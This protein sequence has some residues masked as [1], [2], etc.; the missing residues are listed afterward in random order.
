[1]RYDLGRKAGKKMVTIDGLLTQGKSFNEVSIPSSLE[2]IDEL[3]PITQDFVDFN[4]RESVKNEVMAALKDEE[5]YLIGV[6]GMGGV[7]KTMLMNQMRKQVQEEKLF[8]KVIL[9]TVS[10]NIDMKMIQSEIAERLILNQLKEKESISLRA[11]ILS[12]RLK[13]EKSILVILDD[14]SSANLDLLPQLGIVYGENGHKGGCKVVITSRSYDVCNSMLCQKTIQ[15]RVLSD[16]EAWNLFKKNAGDVV[17]SP[18]LETLARGI[19]KQCKGL[20]IA[21]HTLGR[22][23]RNNEDKLMWKETASQLANNCDDVILGDLDQIKRTL[24][25]VL[26]K[27]IA[28]SL[29]M[30]AIHHYRNA[31]NISFRMH[32]IVRDVAILIASEEGNGVFV[33]AGKGLSKW[34]KMGSLLSGKCLRL[35]LMRNEISV[36]PDQLP[37]LPHLLSLSFEGNKALKKFPDGFF[38]TMGSLTTLDLRQTGISSLPSSFLFLQNLRSLYLDSSDFSQ[39]KDIAEIGKLKNLEMLSLKNCKLHN[40]PEEF[41]GL[42]TLKLLD[43]GDNKLKVVPPNVISRLSRLEYLDMGGSLNYDKWEIEGDWE[44]G[45]NA[46]LAEVTSLHSLS[47]VKLKLNKKSTEKDFKHQ[48]CISFRI[49]MDMIY[50]G[51]CTLSLTPL[52]PICDSIK[53]LLRRVERLI[54]SDCTTCLNSL[55]QLVSLGVV[56]ENIA[57]ER[58]V[59]KSMDKMKQI[60]NGPIPVEYNCPELKDVFNLEEES[61]FLVIEE[62]SVDDDTFFRLREIH[63]YLLP[64]LETIFMPNGVNISLGCVEN[65]KIVKIFECHKLRYLFS[66]AMLRSLQQLEELEIE[67]CYSMVSIIKSEA[68]IV[69]EDHQAVL[70]PAPDHNNITTTTTL[71]QTIFPNLKV[72]IIRDCKSLRQL[73]DGKDFEDFINVQKHENNDEQL[74]IQQVLHHDKKPIVLPLLNH[75]DSPGHTPSGKDLRSHACNP[76]SRREKLFEGYTFNDA[77]YSE[78]RL[79]MKRSG[80]RRRG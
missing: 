62:G 73:W 9:T 8:D 2:G 7:G 40:F 34:P 75:F 50:Y 57:L 63:L 3:G 61:E 71:P 76:Y 54:A 29:L 35:S 23:L 69:V 67:W 30:S 10:H 27:L 70:V 52:F 66:T 68:E 44:N 39:F 74:I 13:Q 22:A 16:E 55:G 78:G 72:L 77:L 31:G 45:T 48:R 14:L 53:E 56:E 25:T 79:L 49:D 80:W 38:Q 46:S 17:E 24:H 37:E 19:V 51:Y 36:L 64:N 18:A 33:K 12:V 47:T 60:V 65:L 15:V 59:I 20:P 28:S 6:H 43:L 4:S 26:K 32:D 11:E 5:T 41:G 58:L 21:L 42:T 1:M